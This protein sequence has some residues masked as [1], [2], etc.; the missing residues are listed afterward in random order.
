V[1]ILVLAVAACR[2][3]LEEGVIARVNDYL[4]TVEEV[5]ER[6]ARLEREAG[7]SFTGKP[8][9]RRELQRAI[10]RELVDRKL[11][12]SEARARGVVVRNE[13]LEE[14]RGRRYPGLSGADLEEVL[15]KAGLT[16]ARLDQFLREELTLTRLVEGISQEAVTDADVAAAYREDR[17]AMRMPETVTIRQITLP[18]KEDAVRVRR[19]LLAG[20][21][22]AALAREHSQGPQGEQ[23]GEPESFRRGELPM[24]LEEWAFALHAGQ[25]SQI[26]ESPFGFHV[27]KVEGHA[28][29][30]TLTPEEAGK[31]IRRR[32]GEERREAAV[33]KLL[34]HLA[35]RA[36]I[37]YNTRH[38][39]Y[40]PRGN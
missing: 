30:R 32:L 10:V 19:R 29:E 13:E 31:G 5:E 37:D 34:E 15:R 1:A 7:L 40:L 11:L 20:E 23:K 35:E 26:I 16:Q 9:E 12:L 38:A 8:L 39:D 36:A 14:E 24:E 27:L 17:E 6:L 2:P 33:K 22:P 28:P 18:L 4:L 3:R 21:D 25:V